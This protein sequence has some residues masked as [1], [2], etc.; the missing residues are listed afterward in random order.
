MPE[1][2]QKERVLGRET[3]VASSSDAAI[4][5]RVEELMRG[6][7]GLPADDVLVEGEILSPIAQL[8]P[9]EE[10]D[11][12]GQPINIIPINTK[13]SHRDSVMGHSLVKQRSSSKRAA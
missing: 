8:V 6:I 5:A 1:Y 3:S 10:K 11:L 7:K 12:R 2:D 13:V 9:N 4:E